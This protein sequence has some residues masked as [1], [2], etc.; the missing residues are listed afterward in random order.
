MAERINHTVLL[1]DVRIAYRNFSG[2]EDRYNQEG[3]IT[4]LT[5]LDEETAEQM[6]AEGWSV[7]RFNPRED[8]GE[9]EEGE[10]FLPVAIRYDKG[11]PPRV[12]M[13]TSRG[14]T[15]LDEST[16][17]ILDWADIIHVDL[18][19]RPYYWE[20]GGKSGN[21]AYVQALYVTIEEDELE[22]KYAELDAQ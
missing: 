9:A 3:R 17:E 13:I 11:R 2:K 12:V 22:R 1:E 15:N 10:P 18:I 19:V 8:D 7:K 4:F 16:I 20:V 14:R 21:K 6:A 5:V